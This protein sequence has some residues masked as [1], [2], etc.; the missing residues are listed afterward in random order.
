MVGDY[1]A[2]NCITQLDCFHLPFLYDFGD[3]LH[4]CI[5]FSKLDCLKG[6][7]QIPMAPQDAAKTAIITP[8]GLYRFKMM[9]FGLRN[10]GNTYQRFIDQVTRGLDFCFVYVDGI[11]I[12]SRSFEEHKR[13]LRILLD[14]F[15]QHGVVLNK[16]KCEF[17]VNQLTFLGHHISFEGFQTKPEKMLAI[18]NFSKLKTMSHLRRFLGMLNYYKCFIPLCAETVRLLKSILFRAKSSKKLI[19]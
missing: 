7:H 8:V 10:S 9:P 2:L 11:L 14:R 15:R 17:V 4:D 12:A 16:S 18:Q 19:E 6:Y 13:H 1:K 3:V 5:V